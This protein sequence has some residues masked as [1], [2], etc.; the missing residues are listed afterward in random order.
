MRQSPPSSPELPAWPVGRARSHLRLQSGEEEGWTRGPSL[1]VS[2]PVGLRLSEPPSLHV[3]SSGEP[4]RPRAPGGPAKEQIL[5]SQPGLGS[6]G[7]ILL[8]PQSSHKGTTVTPTLPHE[9]TPSGFWGSLPVGLGSQRGL[10]TS[11]GTCPPAKGF[12][13]SPFAGDGKGPGRAQGW[14]KP[15]CRRAGSQDA[16]RTLLWLLT[17]SPNQFLKAVPR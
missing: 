2:P 6:D 14:K 4:G 9:A 16:G 5:S 13:L 1:W 17:G 15:P 7:K 3:P 12:F 8:Y 10:R 11:P